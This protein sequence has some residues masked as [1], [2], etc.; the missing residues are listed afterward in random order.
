MATIYDGNGN[1]LAAGLQGCNAS[2]EAV[3]LAKRLANERGEAVTLED[4]GEWEI[5]PDEDAGDE[6]VTANVT[7]A[8]QTLTAAV[9]AAITEFD[10]INWDNHM[11]AIANVLEAAK[12][13]RLR[14]LVYDAQDGDLEHGSEY[15]DDGT[16]DSQRHRREIA[17]CVEALK[18]LDLD[19]EA[20]VTELARKF[21]ALADDE[22]TYVTSRSDA[23][24]DLGR[25]AVEAAQAGDYDAALGLAKRAY[26]IE[27]EFGDA[28]AWRPVYAAAE[29]LVEAAEDDDDGHGTADDARTAFVELA[30]SLAAAMEFEE[31]LLGAGVDGHP[32]QNTAAYWEWLSEQLEGFRQD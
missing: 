31:G 29:A 25:E 8:V 30:G 11:D 1:E 27:M 12:P 2:D 19:D 9:E 21:R 15:P 22:A 16:D 24:A 14:N 10:G 6:P 5:E 32:D 4:D 7:A 26:E 20:A 13:S 18:S 3:N 23:A 17:E 28:A